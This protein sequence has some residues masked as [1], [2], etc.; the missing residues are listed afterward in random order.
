[1]RRPEAG[2]RNLILL[3]RGLFGWLGRECLGLFGELREA[4]GV[5]H[6]HVSQDFAIEGNS[7]GFQA[8]D[9]LAIGDAILTCSGADALNPQAAILALLYTAVAE[10]I[11][12]RAIGRFLRGLIELALGEE[13]AL[14]PLEILLTPGPAFSAAFYA[15]HGFAPLVFR[16]TKRVAERRENAP[17]QRVCFRGICSCLAA[18]PPEGGRYMAGLTPGTIRSPKRAERPAGTR[19]ALPGTF[20]ETGVSRFLHGRHKSAP[21]KSKN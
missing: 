16:E 17:S 11:A 8:M 9:Q 1:M 7:R 10:C 4:G 6:C 5:L 18:W 19:V 15:W 13:K 3:G 20:C 21:T 2:E 14:G 12:I